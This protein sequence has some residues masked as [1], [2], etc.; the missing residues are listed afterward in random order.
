[1]C[2]SNSLYYPKEKPWKDIDK[3][4]LVKYPGIIAGS[5]GWYRARECM[6]KKF[7]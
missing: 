4:V 3:A 5:S 2:C 1:M 7:H 6:A